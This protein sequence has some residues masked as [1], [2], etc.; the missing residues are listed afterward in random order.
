MKNSK[1]LRMWQ[2]RLRVNAAAWAE[3]VERMER[4]EQL[5]AGSDEIRPIV[6]G[7]TC[8]RAPH[9]R[10]ICAEL[11][12]AQVDSNIPL[13]KVTAR[14]PQDARLARRIEDMLRNEMDRLSSEQINDLAERIVPVQGGCGFLAEWDCGAS[15]GG[16]LALRCI[17]PRQI[18]PQNGVTEG[19]EQMDYFILKLPQTKEMIFRRYGI[20]VDGETEEEPEV[21]C[22]DAA[23][24]MVTL[25]VGYYRNGCG[26]LG[27]YAWVGE[28]ELEDL[29]DYQLRRLRRCRRCGAPELPGLESLAPTEDGTPGL[30]EVRSGCPYCGAEDWEETEEPVEELY[31]PIVRAD[32]SVIPGLHPVTHI[33]E[34]GTEHTELEPT[35]IPY[36]R[37]DRYPL[38]LQKNVSVYGRLL[39]ESDIDKIEDQFNTTSR[40]ESKIIDKLLKSGSYIT[41]PDEV[42]I[43][44]DAEDMKVIRPGNAANKALIG[45][46]DLQGNIGQ[47]M[48]YLHQVYEE[49]RQ[50]IGITDSYQGRVDRSATSGRAKEFAAAQSAGRLESKRVLKY[51]AYAALYETMFRLKLAYCDEPSPVVSR[52]THGGTVY[53]EFSRYDFLEQDET[54]AWVYNDRFLFSCDASAPLASNREAMWQETRMNLQTGAFGDPAA[55]ETL[56]LFWT[57]MDQLQYPGAADTL[58]YLKGQSE[59]KDGQVWMN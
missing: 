49:S 53:S 42:S 47:D 35:R 7:D 54:G 28:T 51:A 29:E 18:I 30:P 19:V 43:R 14:R 11:I 31:Q 15:P 20:R 4:R 10:N 22:G 21:R 57:R 56:I 1:K 36:Y 25:Y 32:G 37:P 39:G 59:G 24:D 52:D 23:E 41:L 46:Y 26:G 45:V 34:D 8:T 3:E 38:V 55:P 5:Y 44:A 16:E 27:R 13:P 48:Q 2:E 17:H 50:I 9:V 40:I 58:D 33:D 6:D 12:E